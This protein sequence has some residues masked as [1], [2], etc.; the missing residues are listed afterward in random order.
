[1]ALNGTGRRKRAARRITRWPVAGTM[2]GRA[3]SWMRTA[4]WNGCLS[5]R[6]LVAPVGAVA[7]MA[8]VRGLRN[9]D[10]LLK[11]DDFLPKNVDFITMKTGTA[12]FKAL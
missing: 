5:A 2:R 1:M 11:N 10:F 4:I 8:R 9:G 6:C 7:A 12:A 3:L